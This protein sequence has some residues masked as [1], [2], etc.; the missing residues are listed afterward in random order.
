MSQEAPKFFY[1]NPTDN[2]GT[3]I[4]QSYC[5]IAGAQTKTECESLG[6]EWIVTEVQ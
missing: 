1:D 3:R 4:T 2:L 5:T 6:G